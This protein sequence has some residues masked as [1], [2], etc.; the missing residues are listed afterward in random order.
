M[1]PEDFKELVESR[2]GIRIHECL[3][4][5]PNIGSLSRRVRV[6]PDNPGIKIWERYN[7]RKASVIP[8]KDLEYIETD[9][10]FLILK[11]RLGYAKDSYL[12]IQL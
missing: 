4:Q 9:E 2:I 8:C 10:P 7:S 12:V 1:T 5:T 6:I 11:T 3:V